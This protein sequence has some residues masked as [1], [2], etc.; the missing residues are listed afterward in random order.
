MHTYTYIW[1]QTHKVSLIGWNSD[2]RLKF[3]LIFSLSFILSV[4][5]HDFF[6]RTVCHLHSFLM[7][8]LWKVSQLYSDC[9]APCFLLFV[10]M[11]PSVLKVFMLLSLK[12]SPLCFLLVTFTLNSNGEKTFQIFRFLFNLAASFN[13]L[14]KQEACNVSVKSVNR[15]LCTFKATSAD[16]SVKQFCTRCCEVQWD[17]GD[18]IS[19]PAIK[20]CA[21]L[22]FCYWVNKQCV[23]NKSLLIGH[24]SYSTVLII[25]TVCCST[26]RC[27][28]MHKLPFN[29]ER[30]WDRSPWRLSPAG[31]FCWVWE[32]QQS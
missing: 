6:N 21:F 17:H 2:L 19:Y 23:E 9:K 28:S 26:S 14:S 25:Q 5:Q 16:R 30:M 12:P 8:V 7:V 18:I 11:K 24:F 13:S 32:S 4:H 3:I 27:V 10:L 29:A 20:A 22:H 15:F 1:K 31:W